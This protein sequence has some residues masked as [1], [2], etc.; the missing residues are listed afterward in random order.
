MLISPD[1]LLKDPDARQIIRTVI[2]AL[3]PD[4]NPVERAW[5]VAIIAIE[6]TRP[7]A[8]ENGKYTGALLGITMR[9]CADAPE[10]KAIL[11]AYLHTIDQAEGGTTQGQ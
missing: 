4:T 11:D 2:K 6:S 1:D 7:G 8:G 10:G 3:H 5:A 9:I